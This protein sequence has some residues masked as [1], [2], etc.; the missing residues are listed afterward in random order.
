MHEEAPEYF[1][2]GD[3]EK[4]MGVLA[5]SS[6]QQSVAM[7][8]RETLGFWKEWNDAGRPKFDLDKWK[9]FGDAARKGWEED[10]SPR[11][12]GMEMV[13]LCTGITPLPDLSGKLRIFC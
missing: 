11:S 10:G 13:L 2:E 7:N 4:F 1:K 3:K 9:E 12:R 8:L 6:P 5:G